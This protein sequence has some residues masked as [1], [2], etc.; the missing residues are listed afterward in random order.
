MCI[1]NYGSHLEHHY[2][3]QNL[4][5]IQMFIS[6][7]YGNLWPT[8][9]IYK[10]DLRSIRFYP[11]LFVFVRFF[12]SMKKCRIFRPHLSLPTFAKVSR[13]RQSFS[14]SISFIYLFFVKDTAVNL[15]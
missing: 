6:P 5:N 4:S 2:V 14:I 7:M 11:L 12:F 1:Q 13:S 3:N 8:L 15:F 9:Y 10:A